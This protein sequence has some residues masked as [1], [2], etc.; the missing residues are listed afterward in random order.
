MN[1]IMRSKETLT[2][3]PQ[4]SLPKLNS[5]VIVDLP[6]D[7]RDRGDIILLRSIDSKVHDYL[8]LGGGKVLAVALLATNGFDELP[9]LLKTTI[10]QNG[11]GDVS[12]VDVGLVGRVDIDKMRAVAGP[13]RELWESLPTFL[14]SYRL[15]SWSTPQ[16][17]DELREK[18]KVWWRSVSLAG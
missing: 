8:V 12:V 5:A 18:V 14:S 4:H 6:P 11:F 3:S 10:D 16:R 13:L 9:Q 7:G 1:S 17:P 15:R 2:L